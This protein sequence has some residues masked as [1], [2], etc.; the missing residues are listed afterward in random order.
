MA[1]RTIARIQHRRGIK[2]DLPSNLYEGELGWC[3]D[4]REL[5]IGNGEPFSG[6]TQVVTANS[7]N[8]TLITNLWSSYSIT[9]RASQLR[10][11]NSKVNDT[12]SV[13]DFGAMGDGEHDDAPLINAAIGQMFSAGADPLPD[14]TAL[15][16]TLHF[17]AGVYLIKS[18]IKL[19]PNTRLVGDG[20]GS[21]VILLGDELMSHLMESADSL[22]QTDINQGLSSALLPCRLMISDM[23]INTA[24]QKIDAIRLSRYNGAKVERVEFIGGYQPADQA[25]YD[26]SAVQLDHLSNP[27]ADTLDALVQ[28]CSINHFTYGVKL[29][30]TLGSTSIAYNSFANC[31]QGVRIGIECGERGAYNTTIVANH[32]SDLDNSGI[33]NRSTYS[34]CTSIG[35]SFANVGT[36]DNVSPIWWDVGTNV[37][38]SI[39]DMFDSGLVVLPVNN[40]GNTN[41][42]LDAQYNNLPVGPGPGGGTIASVTTPGLYSASLTDSIILVATATAAAQVTIGLPG[43]ATNGHTLII[44]DVEDSANLYNILI[45]PAGA[46][47]VESGAPDLAMTSN[48]QSVTLVYITA[49]T[50][51]VIV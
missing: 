26:A 9:P 32:F 14:L 25:A 22:G 7:N 19:L 10:T 41:L 30:G 36:L 51:W 27:L 39:G 49:L 34:G 13:K 2:T 8:S 50:K 6:N 38:H 5:F 4:T 43:A 17:P 1:V 45:S 15:Q 28:G 20:M 46:D 16:P 44:K 21:T 18:P 37:C 11:I 47:S 33:H 35:N 12:A 31:W 3:M 48:S 24:G 40:L 29:V 42:I 23:T